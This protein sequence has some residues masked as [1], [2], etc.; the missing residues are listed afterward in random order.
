MGWVRFTA[1]GVFA[2]CTVQA[3]SFR[4]CVASEEVA[5]PKNY[6]EFF[7]LSSEATPDEIR[8][9]AV[10]LINSLHP[11]RHSGDRSTEEQYREAVQAYQTLKDPE[12]RREYNEELYRKKSSHIVYQGAVRS[13]N[14]DNPMHTLEEILKYDWP[15]FNSKEASRFVDSLKSIP[16]GSVDEMT[17][18]IHNRLEAAIIQD[19]GNQREEFNVFDVTY[20]WFAVLKNKLDTSIVKSKSYGGLEDY[21]LYEATCRAYALWLHDLRP[22]SQ[23]TADNR[24][25]SFYKSLLAEKLDLSKK[26]QEFRYPKRQA[27]IDNILS[28]INDIHGTAPASGLA[29]E[30]QAWA[31]IADINRQSDWTPEIWEKVPHLMI[32]ADPSIRKQVVFRLE[33][34]SNW[35]R[36]VW[37]TVPALLNDSNEVIHE[38]MRAA[39]W[40]HA[41]LGHTAA[42][43]LSIGDPTLT[44]AIVY[45]LS[46]SKDWS[47][48]VWEQMIALLKDPRHQLRVIHSMMEQPKLPDSVWAEIPALMGNPDFHVR[49]QV[50]KLLARHPSDWT[51]QVWAGIPALLK[52]SEHW[53]RRE[54]DEAL[55]KQ[56]K[57]SDVLWE[58][59]PALLKDEYYIR[60]SAIKI[61][62][63]QNQWPKSFLDQAQGLEKELRDDIKTDF[64]RLRKNQVSQNKTSLWK[65]ASCILDFI[66]GGLK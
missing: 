28:F 18:L 36:E 50:A 62:K 63:S 41:D 19:M 8:K 47:P 16:R 9:V 46:Q 5:Q 64:V 56:P 57:L 3:F 4:M 7:K 51:P 31:K 34:Q 59:I 52:D 43:P 61:L 25:L 38:A 27:S 24:L 26:S 12:K 21:P 33:Q 58:Q 17:K 11:D 22:F 23:K 20:D 44:D 1:I 54:I 14:R 66:K 49:I 35:P 65:R 15:V 13:P 45:R 6:Y 37:A 39:I 55:V 48:Q 60:H 10:P 40:Q 32:D 42:V 30:S 2:F 29:L 53:V